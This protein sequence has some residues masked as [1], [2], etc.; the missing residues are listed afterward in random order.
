MPAGKLYVIALYATRPK[1][2]ERPAEHEVSLRVAMTVAASDEEAKA[3]GRAQL[4]EWCPPAAGWLNHHVTL[5]TI[6]K[7]SLLE[8]LG[9]VS[10]EAA[11]E[12]AD[13]LDWPEVL[14]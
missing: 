1:A 7:R 8:L 11:D 6:S 3:K 14:P 5:S 13:N 9:H 12:D 2:G 4:F 10:D